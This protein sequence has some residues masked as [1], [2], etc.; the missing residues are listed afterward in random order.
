[1][2]GTVVADFLQPQSAYGLTIQTP[3]G[4]TIA[5]INS[6]G[7]FSNT[8]YQMMTANGF[9]GNIVATFVGVGRSSASSFNENLS[10]AN[11]IGI[12]SSGSGVRAN[13]YFNYTNSLI[14]SM[15]DGTGTGMD[16]LGIVN[17]NNGVYVC[18][19]NFGGGVGV[20][21]NTGT[22][23]AQLQVN[24]ASNSIMGN[25]NGILLYNTN[26]SGGQ[27]SQIGFGGANTP[28]SYSVFIG[29]DNSADG[30]N[31]NTLAL[32][33]TSATNSNGIQFYT[34]NTVRTTIAPTGQTTISASQMSSSSIYPVIVQNP[35]QVGNSRNC[36]MYFD[37]SAAS[38]Y[39]SQVF[40]G[41]LSSSRTP[42]QIIT[43]VPANGG[44]DLNFYGDGGGGVVLSSNTSTSW[45]GRSDIRLKNITGT[46][47]TPLNDIAKLEVIKFTWKSDESNT[48]CVGVSAQ[49]VVPVIPEAIS[50]HRIDLDL[51]NGD[52]TEYLHVRYTELIP[53]AIASIQELKSIVSSQA[54][55][56]VQLQSRLAAANI[57]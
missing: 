44:T 21:A 53:L 45:S 23:Q 48:P 39:S 46:Y 42:W 14:S 49:S 24:G 26:T 31:A 52:P 22:V 4:N 13:L 29:N 38:G 2:A 12:I 51:E 35:G 28:G 3:S 40:F 5:T 27:S 30:T 7:I 17:G 55:T 1:M 41:R 16:G 20:G 34:N 15:K 32:G 57:A 9:T 37:S 6:A 56:I 25:R 50:Q 8:G 18:Y 33:T 11:S 47:T 54:N 10:V 43:D 19:T 36:G